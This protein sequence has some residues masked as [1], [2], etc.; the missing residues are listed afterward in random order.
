MVTESGA[1][2]TLRLREDAVT[3][4][5]VGDEVVALDVA[6]SMYLGVNPSGAVVWTALAAGATRQELVTLLLERFDV[7]T[8]EASRDIDA[9]LTE[10]SELGLLEQLPAT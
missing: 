3:W 8:E 7:E 5:L 9:L 1:D 10:L 2:E 4:R 6:H